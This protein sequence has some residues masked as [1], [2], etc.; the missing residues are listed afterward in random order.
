MEMI[1]LEK[2]EWNDNKGINVFEEIESFAKDSH[3]VDVDDKLGVFICSV[4]AHIFNALNKC[5]RC[6]F[7]PTTV[8]D[9]DEDFTIDNCPLRHSNPAFYTPMMQLKD[10]RIHILLRGPKGSGKSILILL[11]LAEGTL[12]VGHWRV[13]IVG[14]FLALK[15]FL[16]C[17]MPPRKTTH[18]I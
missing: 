11:F 6:D 2:P 16:Q 1:C 15:N 14:A 3:Y 18:S 8:A 13:K 9:P 17:L 4:G 7:D 10:T 5:S 12:S